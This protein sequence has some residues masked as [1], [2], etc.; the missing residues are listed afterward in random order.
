MLNLSNGTNLRI[1]ASVAG[2]FRVSVSYVDVTAGISTAVNGIVIAPVTGTTPV[3]IVPTPPVGTIRNVKQVTVHNAGGAQNVATVDQFNGSTSIPRNVT[4]PVSWRSE[5]DET[6]D[7]QVFD[8]DGKKVSLGQQGPTGLTGP[9]G[10]PGANGAPGTPGTNGVNGTPAALLRITST[11]SNTIGL[12]SKTF[13]F[14][15]STMAWAVGSTVRAINSA[16]NWCEGLVTAASATSVTIDIDTLGPIAAAG[17]FTSWTLVISGTSVNNDYVDDQIA[18]LSGLI[19][20][21]SYPDRGS[22][23]APSAL[24]Q[25]IAV[26]NDKLFASDGNRLSA[27][28]THKSMVGVV[29]QAG[30]G[31]NIREVARFKYDAQELMQ[32]TVRVKAKVEIEAPVAVTTGTWAIEVKLVDAGQPR[33]HSSAVILFQVFPVIQ[34]HKHW[35][36]DAAF[37]TSTVAQVLDLYLNS[38]QNLA[39]TG[40]DIQGGVAIQVPGLN[41]DLMVAKDITISVLSPALTLA[42]CHYATVETAPETTQDSAISFYG[43]SITYGVGSTVG[44]DYP[45]IVSRQLGRTVRN[46]GFSGQTISQIGARAM[47]DAVAWKKDVPIY[48][49]MGRNNAGSPT[50][51]ADWLA[52]AAILFANYSKI[53]FG[54]VTTGF[55]ETIG[56]ATR[57]QID[58]LNTVIRNTYPNNH[59]DVQAALAINAGEINS[60][61]FADNVGNQVHFSDSGYLKIATAV[62]NAITAKGW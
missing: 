33:S 11:T 38:P 29:T 17:P 56:N 39:T 22:I 7:W 19:A 45:S 40:A 3:E 34:T 62:A 27:I 18:A 58:A 25:A 51:Q 37:N 52:Q 61:D 4:L 1:K 14:A 50:I 31:T 36:L 12:G 20:V 2:D 53:L 16:D 5:F 6:G 30:D 26:A 35:I 23:P 44:Q 9:A 21:K 15:S 59:V 10:A 13:G 46:Y 28:P 55:T 24:G 57:T 32:C 48:V 43:D 60:A 47:L 42:K 8:Q 49:S 54:T 41:P